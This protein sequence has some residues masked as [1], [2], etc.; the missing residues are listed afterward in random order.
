MADDMRCLQCNESQAAIRAT[1]RLREPLH[2]G[3][4]DYFGEAEWTA[5]RHRFRDWTDREL[6]DGFGVKPEFVGLYR[7]VMSGYEI[8]DEHSARPAPATPEGEQK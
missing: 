6:I 7:R 2:C 8:A 4:V 1:Q 5:E 3:A